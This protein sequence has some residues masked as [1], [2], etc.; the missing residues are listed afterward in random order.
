MSG[1][2]TVTAT[3]LPATPVVSVVDNCDG[4]STL[5]ITNPE[6]GATFAWNGGLTGNPATANVAGN[7]VVTQE[8]GGC[9]SLASVEAVAA[10]KTTPATPVVTVMDNCG[11]SDL[12]TTATGTL[13]WSTGATTS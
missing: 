5:T 9:I 13:L 11:N 4:T 7:Y 1:S 8:I 3:A 12:S 10:P 2:A 6:V